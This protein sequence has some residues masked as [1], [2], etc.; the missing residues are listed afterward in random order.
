MVE[1]MSMSLPVIATNFSGPTGAYGLARLVL[2]AYSIIMSL[3]VLLKNSST[4]PPTHTQPDGEALLHIWT[5]THEP[6]LS[7]TGGIYATR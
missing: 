6:C 2:A 3:F 4:H 1:A 5:Y 7:H